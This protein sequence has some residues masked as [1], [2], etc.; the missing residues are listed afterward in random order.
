MDSV[1]IRLKY[2]PESGNQQAR[3]PVPVASDQVNEKTATAA[4]NGGRHFGF[5]RADSL[6]GRRS[7]HGLY[8]QVSD[9][10]LRCIT[11]R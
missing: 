10:Q 9:R 3:L 4:R 2:N 11:K 5:S 6:I 1:W 8:F 7:N